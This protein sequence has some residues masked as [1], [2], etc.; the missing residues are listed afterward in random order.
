ME[1]RIRAALMALSMA[2][3]SGCGSGSSSSSTDFE[4]VWHGTYEANGTRVPLTAVAGYGSMY[5]YDDDG[6]VFVIPHI[7]GA[8]DVDQSGNAYP[9]HGFIF[10][11]GSNS[12]DVEMKASVSAT[13]ITGTLTIDGADLPVALHASKPLPGDPS[14]VAGKWYGDFFSPYLAVDEVDLSGTIAADGTITGIE[15][16]NCLI[17]GTITQALDGSNLF[18][19]SVTEYADSGRIGGCG[20]TWTGVAYESNTDQVDVFGADPGPYYHMVGSNARGAIVMEIRVK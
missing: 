4:G 13:Q 19:I 2:L 7:S 8:G 3:L 9:A 5:L 14:V 16:D 10:D 6:L 17:K 11:N 1:V 12:M 15:P 18:D 20:G